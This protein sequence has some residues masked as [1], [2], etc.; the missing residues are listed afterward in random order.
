MSIT[1]INQI[2]KIKVFLRLIENEESF[3]IACSKSGLNDLDAKEFL[4]K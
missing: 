1:N 2:E 4:Q 3:E